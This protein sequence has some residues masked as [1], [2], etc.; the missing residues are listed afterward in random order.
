MF[1]T[2]KSLL[3]AALVTAVVLSG[4]SVK[5]QDTSASQP[6]SIPHLSVSQSTIPE[7]DASVTQPDAPP[8]V[9]APEPAQSEPATPPALSQPEPESCKHS[10]TTAVTV[11]VATCTAQG[12][13]N[14]VCA[15]CG[16]VIA[17]GTIPPQGHDYAQTTVVEATCETDG[18]R[19]TTCSRCGDVQT[20]AIPTLDHS[21]S[22]AVCG[23]PATCQLCGITSPTATEHSWVVKYAMGTPEC[24]Y[25]GTK[26]TFDKLVIRSNN[27]NVPILA[28][29]K[30]ITIIDM[31]YDVRAFEGPFNSR[32][33]CRLDITVEG[34]ASN[35]CTL[36]RGS[37]LIAEDGTKITSI[38]ENHGTTNPVCD[39]S[40]TEMFSFDIPS[41]EG[42]YT[43]VFSAQ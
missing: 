36:T 31:N 7:P 4:C 3:A 10:K 23:S 29:T 9:S 16:E 34:M 37:H 25:C 8:A 6:D 19:A 1:C 41:C 20:E 2:K 28:G 18:S 33:V 32:S 43:V 38:Y 21:W 15:A 14:V 13:E 11:S 22:A 30:S 39:G 17:S 27:L 24:E 35:A 40:F 12:H 26:Y 42:T 5:P